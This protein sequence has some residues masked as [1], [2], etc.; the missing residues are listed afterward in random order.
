MIDDVV[1]RRSVLDELS[2]DAT[3]D[4]THVGVTAVDGVVTLT[5]H[6]HSYPEIFAVRKCVRRVSGVKAVADEL[7]VRLM[8]DDRREDSD[9]AESIVHVLQHNITLPNSN[10]QAEVRQGLVTLL[11]KVDWQY[12]R[13]H[14][15]KQIAH[16]SGVLGVSNQIELLPRVTPA[17]VKEQI[18]NALERNAELEAQHVSVEVKGDEVI[19]IGSVKAYYERNII[20]AAAWSAPGVHKVTD[21]ISVG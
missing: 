16:V 21:K 13:Q 5:G 14:V 18:E 12:Q 1:L 17:D 10:I 8:S 6:V 4:A 7:N 3:V 19:L 15:E 11:G 2:W 9:I 20:E